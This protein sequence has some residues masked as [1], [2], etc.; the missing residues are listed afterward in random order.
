MIK[1]LLNSALIILLFSF[2]SFAQDD[3]EEGTKSAESF[4]KEELLKERH[5]L[6]FK[7]CFFESIQQKNIENYD[8]ALESLSICE[9]IFPDN[10]AMLFEKAKN[11]F[12]LKQYIEAQHYCTKALSLNPDNFWVLALSRDIY[13]K[14]HNYPEAINIQ[15]KLY[16]VK[17]S[18]AGGLLKLYY[19]TKKIK[20][21]QEFLVEVERKNI[22]VLAIDF[23]KKQFKEKIENTKEY[24]AKG[25]ISN[26]KDINALKDEFSRTNSFQIL[27][28]ILEKEASKKQFEALLKDSNLGLSLF[29]AQATVYLYSGL[30]LN[31]LNKHKEAVIV[32]ETGLDFVFDNPALIKQFYNELI[33]GYRKMKNIDKVNHYKHMVQKLQ[34]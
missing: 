16:A 24:T 27:Q 1:Y 32:L 12:H 7:K 29:P 4:E 22:Y 19:R 33:I 23:Y 11:H 8:K 6:N 18:E 15:K 20:E 9:S 25:N 34:P 5:A 13:E 26:S 30:A 10:E 31:A 2:T 21:G 28:Q 3:S 14:E 17:K